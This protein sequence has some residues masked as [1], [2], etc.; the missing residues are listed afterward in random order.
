MSNSPESQRKYRVEAQS[1][2]MN[3]TNTNASGKPIHM[4]FEKLN[5]HNDSSQN[6][7]SQ[8]LNS[9]NRGWR[10]PFDLSD[11]NDNLGVAARQT[12]ENNSRKNSDDSSG[13]YNQQRSNRGSI[14]RQS[15]YGGKTLENNLASA[16]QEKPSKNAPIDAQKDKI[17]FKEEIQEIKVVENWK[18]YNN[19]DYNNTTCHC[20]TF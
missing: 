1:N 3:S 19:D 13:Y 7:Y 8:G 17:S 20:C 2:N 9:D 11:V 6:R 5:L 14:L 12:K 18:E 10:I 16:P 15:K 4:Q